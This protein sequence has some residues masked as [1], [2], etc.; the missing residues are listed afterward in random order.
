MDERIEKQ[1]YKLTTLGQLQ[2]VEIDYSRDFIC[3]EALFTL[4]TWGAR[5]KCWPEP[6]A[7]P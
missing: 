5:K 7:T 6:S 1:L 4:I 3:E 2:F